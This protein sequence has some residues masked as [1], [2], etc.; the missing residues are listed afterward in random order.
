MESEDNVTKILTQREI[1]KNKKFGFVSNPNYNLGEFLL[2]IPEGS[3][4]YDNR[5]VFIK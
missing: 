3:N 4:P 2:N 5:F 1:L